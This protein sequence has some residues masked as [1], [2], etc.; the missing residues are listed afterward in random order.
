MTTTAAPVYTR[1]NYF[2][3]HAIADSK[4]FVRAA[5]KALKDVDFD[6]IVV[7]GLSGM[8]AGSILAHSMGKNLFVIR[9]QGEQAHDWR[10]AFGAMGQKWIFID[11]LLDSGSTY[12][13]V[14]EHMANASKDDSFEMWDSNK[15]AYITI[16]PEFV[17]AYYYV[18]MEWTK[19]KGWYPADE[20]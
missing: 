8:G 1:H 20:C 9:K 10:P 6:T 3:Q 19:P 13:K 2:S 18:G 14:Q 15:G 17:G 7:T 11:D 4:K 5:R 12:R 16:K